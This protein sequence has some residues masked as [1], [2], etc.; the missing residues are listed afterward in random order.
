MTTNPMGDGGYALA[1][2]LDV[3]GDDGFTLNQL[4]RGTDLPWAVR[5]SEAVREWVGSVCASLFVLAFVGFV[6]AWK[7][8][9]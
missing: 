6:I 4:K 5:F 3:E 7:S 1:S 8:G 2:P 9:V